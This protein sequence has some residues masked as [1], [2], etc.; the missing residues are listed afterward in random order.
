MIT[1][2]PLI[3]GA[4]DLIMRARIA[5]SA[6]ASLMVWAASRMI[7]AAASGM[8]QASLTPAVAASDMVGAADTARRDVR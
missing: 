4:S 3:T 1:D 5:I 2:I 6:T 8:A 7:S